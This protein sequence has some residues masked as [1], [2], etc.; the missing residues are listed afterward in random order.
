MKRYNRL[1]QLPLGKV[2]PRGW[3]LEQLTRN[4]DG[5]GGHLPELE[6]RMIATPYTT[7]ET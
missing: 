3:L 1:S 7:R 4:R 2:N 5:I 6:P